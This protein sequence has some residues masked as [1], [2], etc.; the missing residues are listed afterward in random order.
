M[1]AVC[2][3]ESL[4]FIPQISRTQGHLQGY[5][6]DIKEDPTTMRMDGIRKCL[7]AKGGV[8]ELK[9]RRVE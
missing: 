8:W 6:P 9:S 7:K 2:R 4:K 5:L 1:Q 3:F